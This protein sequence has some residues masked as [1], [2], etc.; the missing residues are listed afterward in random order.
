MNLILWCKSMLMKQTIDAMNHAHCK[1]FTFLLN[2]FRKKNTLI[3]EL[4]LCKYTI[5]I[6]VKTCFNL[7]NYQITVTRVLHS[8]H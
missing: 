5:L 7:T 1:L 3:S 2:I 8:K 6:Q 4:E